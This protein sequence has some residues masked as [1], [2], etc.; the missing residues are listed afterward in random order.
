MAIP[1]QSGARAHDHKCSTHNNV[2]MN[3]SRLCLCGLCE[4]ACGRAVDHGLV[5]CSVPSFRLWSLLGSEFGDG[6]TNYCSMQRI[7]LLTRFYFHFMFS[8]RLDGPAPLLYKLTMVSGT[9]P[10]IKNKTTS[11]SQQ[12]LLNPIQYNRLQSRRYS[13]CSR[14]LSLLRL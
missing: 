11:G 5:A 14:C 12:P 4:R 10:S 7:C 8:L 3:V 9:S 2:F 1:I 6:S 13:T